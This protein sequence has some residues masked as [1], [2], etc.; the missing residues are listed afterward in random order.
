[1]EIEQ[2]EAFIPQV[3]SSVKPLIGQHVDL[4]EE[5]MAIHVDLNEKPLINTSFAMEK[6]M[7]EIT[8]REHD[9]LPASIGLDI[10]PG[11]RL[12]NRKYKKSLDVSPLWEST[13]NRRHSDLD[14]EQ[15]I[16]PQAPDPPRELHHVLLIFFASKSSLLVTI[17]FEVAAGHPT[18]I[19]PAGAESSTRAPPH[20]SLAKIRPSRTRSLPDPRAESSA[21]A[22]PWSL[23]FFNSEIS[24]R[25]AI[26]FEVQ[27]D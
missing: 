22:P 24:Q 5:F 19:R 14:M 18:A 3:D 7:T 8:R 26:L 11:L 17:L 2:D 16:S 27:A 12:G 13:S 15:H 23:I 9:F 4:N 25:V 20:T 10:G 1:M 21:R 6:Q